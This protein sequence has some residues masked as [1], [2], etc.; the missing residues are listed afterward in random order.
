MKI[1]AAAIF[2]DVRMHKQHHGLSELLA[3]DTRERDLVLFVNRSL[4]AFKAM[5]SPELVAYYK[6]PG[7]RLTLDDF[8]RL[9]QMFGGE[10]LVLSKE[11][12]SQLY[13]VLKVKLKQVG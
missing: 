12:E 1:R 11:V 10:R 6:S 7:E 13:E 5:I 9:P 8:K 2:F 3:T 4:T